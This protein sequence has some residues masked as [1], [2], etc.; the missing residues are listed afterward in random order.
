MLR[1]AFAQ[2]Y[3]AVSTSTSETISVSSPRPAQAKLPIWVTGS[4]ATALRRAAERGDGWM[5]TDIARDRLRDQITF[6]RQ[7]RREVNGPESMDIGAVAEPMYVGS[8]SWDLGSGALHG[9]G[10]C[11]AAQILEY[12]EMGANHVGIRLRLAVI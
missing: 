12:A 8:P 6:L 7:H 4:S 5:P 3:V 11:P 2:E 10:S 1:T 9:D